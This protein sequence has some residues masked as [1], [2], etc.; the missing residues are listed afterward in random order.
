VKAP[1]E[2]RNR[3]IWP[4]MVVVIG[5]TIAMAL[6]PAVPMWIPKRFGF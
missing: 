5:I 2:G 3:A 6:F 1:D 4:F